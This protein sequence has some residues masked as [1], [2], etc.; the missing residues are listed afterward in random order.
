MGK[1]RFAGAINNPSFSLDDAKEYMCA[2]V[3]SRA[4]QVRDAIIAGYS[5]GEMASWPIKIAEA[6]SYNGAD[7]S[8]PNLAAEA[9][10]RGVSTQVLVDKVLAKASM[11]AQ[12]EAQTA[13]AN[14]RHRDA[15]KALADFDAVADY[16]YSIGWPV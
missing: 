11:L 15:I 14:G 5:A 3:D 2:L 16:D 7:A 10:A 8:A 9:V 13:G 6:K 1:E 12:G 4:K